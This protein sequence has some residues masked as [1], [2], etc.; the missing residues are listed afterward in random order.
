M[1][2]VGMWEPVRY[3]TLFRTLWFAGRYGGGKT[4]L[5]VYMAA[6]LVI[7]RY[8]TT[9]VSNLPL[10]LGV[11]GVTIKRGDISGIKDAVLLLDEGWQELEIG[12]S[13]KAVKAWLAYLR[14]DNLHVLLPSVHA[15]AREV[16]NYTIERK[17]NLL[18]FGLPYWVYQWRLITG[19]HSKKDVSMG[20]LYLHKPQR[21]FGSY[22]HEYRPDGERW[23]VYEFGTSTESTEIAGSEA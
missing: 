9:I 3:L 8:A 21:I 4:A 6:Q 18:V 1:M 22:D 20:W 23:F 14:K 10:D 13:A 15:L 19:H 12:S 7:E 17:W 5:A 11:D 2:T 16:S